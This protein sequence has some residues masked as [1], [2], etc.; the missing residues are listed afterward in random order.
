MPPE[1][2]IRGPRI[3]PASITAF[4]LVS[5]LSASAAYVVA[6]YPANDGNAARLKGNDRVRER[7]AELLQAGEAKA[8]L[9]LEQHMNELAV[10]RDLA[11]ANKQISSA[12]AAEVKRGE[13]M[14]YYVERRESAN[15]SY[16]ISDKPM[17]NEEWE[18][19]Y[20]VPNAGGSAKSTN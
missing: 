3:I 8:L 1:D 20:C 14:G 10:L 11:K 12:V 16:V 7:V 2:Q 15:C 6:G 9:T 13:L 19:T 5:G 4:K 17:S 18:A